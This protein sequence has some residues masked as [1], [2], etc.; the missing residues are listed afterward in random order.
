MVLDACRKLIAHLR[1]HKRMGDG[2]LFE[3]VVQRDE[4][5]AYLLGNDVHRRSACQC[6]IH[7][8]HAGIEAIAGIGGHTMLGM[9]VVEALIPVAKRHEVAMPELTAL[10]YACRARGVEQDEERVGCDGGR[11]IVSLA[12]H[13]L[14]VVEAEHGDVVLVEHVQSVEP[15]RLFF[16]PVFWCEADQQA[17]VRILHHEVQALFRV[18]GV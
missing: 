11:R 7:V 10:R 14:V 17:R 1:G 18:A 16:L 15:S 6:R 12:I 9:Q 2:V 3:I 5:E 13:Q 4:V 8:H